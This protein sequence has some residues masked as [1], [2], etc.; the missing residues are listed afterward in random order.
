MIK[1]ERRFCGEVDTTY[2]I[3][4]NRVTTNAFTKLRELDESFIGTKDYMG[5]AWFH[6]HHYRHIMRDI[7][8]VYQRKAIHHQMVD[9]GLKL[10]GTSI[11]HKVIMANVL[12]GSFCPMLG[13]AI[14][15]KDIMQYD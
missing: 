8:T 10:D 7:P 2:K 11:S 15:D 12:R 5:L 1:G 13:R 6:A 3:D 4:L 9:S 14:T